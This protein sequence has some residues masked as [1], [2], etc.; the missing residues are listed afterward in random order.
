MA[1]PM[2]GIGDQH[3]SRS[4]STRS[5][6]W[7][8]PRRWAGGGEVNCP[9]CRGRW[10]KQQP[11]AFEFDGREFV[12]H[13][14]KSCAS[15][16]YLQSPE[17]DYKEHTTDPV[18]LRNYLEADASIEALARIYL[19]C[20]GIRAGGSVL[21]FGGGFG[22]GSDVL[23]Y[24]L[25][26]RPL[27]VEPSAYGLLGSKLLELPHSADFLDEDHPIAN[28][29]FDAIVLAEVIEHV[30]EIDAFADLLERML[31]PGG[32]IALTTPN[33]DY[34]DPSRSS[35][36]MQLALLSPGAHVHMFSAK[37]LA[38][39][40]SRHGLS[41]ALSVTH[42]T[43]SNLVAFVSRS[44][45]MAHQ[46]S[47]DYATRDI[48]DA[49]REYYSATADRLAHHRLSLSGPPQERVAQEAVMLGLRFRSFRSAIWAG[50]WDRALEA[51]RS[52]ESVDFG[53]LLRSE[54]LEEFMLHGRAF[55][56]QQA[57]YEAQLHLA[58]VWSGPQAAAKSF[59]QARRLIAH[60]LTI[61]PSLAVVEADLFW[62][63][64]YH[65]ALAV[66]QVGKRQDA[67]ALLNAIWSQGEGLP[68]D[69][70]AV[71]PPQ[72]PDLLA[73]ARTLTDTLTT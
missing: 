1:E 66:S 18:S 3:R 34:I 8:H 63:A 70:I 61:A 13:R 54:T 30:D 29:V 49:V 68:K 32:C 38:A 36:P 58:G 17:T 4:V 59:A 52:L 22:F 35:E 2:N 57:Y 72:P 33:A 67:I 60:K 43:P 24:H 31:A 14:C 23:R 71:L 28:R 62:R 44:E 41:V 64:V 39:F 19:A 65:E 11:E 51:H 42:S 7:L 26:W 37:G 47:E 20:G 25:G 6:S 21:D 10:G 48:G 53:R 55:A 45:Q 46:C 40:F 5:L 9:V 27:L 56:P 16:S 50:D 69:E 15:L 73:Q 12:L